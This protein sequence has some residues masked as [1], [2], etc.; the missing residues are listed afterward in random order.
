MTQQEILERLSEILRALLA[1]ESISLQPETMRSDI[2]GWDSFQY[3]NFIVAVEAQFGVKFGV[4]DV[5]S[6]R[7]VGDIASELL[8]LNG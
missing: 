4:A 5:E 3:I 8:R 2:D 7:T 6:F 1:D